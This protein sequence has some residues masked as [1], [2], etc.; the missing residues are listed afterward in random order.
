MINIKFRVEGSCVGKVVDGCGEEKVG[1]YDCVGS[2]LI[3]KLNV[4]FIVFIL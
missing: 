1:R 3:L 4:G 2:V